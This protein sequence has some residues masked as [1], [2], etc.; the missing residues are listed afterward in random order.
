MASACREQLLRDL[1]AAT[2][3]IYSVNSSSH[4]Q[5]RLFLLKLSRS[6]Q[7]LDISSF[8]EEHLSDALR[9]YS[10]YETDAVLRSESADDR[11][12]P[13]IRYDNVVLVHVQ[14]PEQLDIAYPNYSTNVRELLEFLDE[15][16]ITP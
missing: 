1:H 11:N 5:D 3:S 4:P 13:E 14:K 9:E 15:Y 8:D 16:G 7:Y 6:D 2:D 12:Q 10:G